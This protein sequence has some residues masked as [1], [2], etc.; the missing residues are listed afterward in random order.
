MNER[1]RTQWKTHVPRRIGEIWALHSHL[2]WSY[3]S[4]VDRHSLPPTNNGCS[5]C[6][7]QPAVSSTAFKS[8]SQESW[9]ATLIR[10]SRRSKCFSQ[11]FLS[12]SFFSIMLNTQRKLI[13]VCVHVKW[14][15]TRRFFS[16]TDATESGHSKVES[17][18]ET[19]C[20][21]S[22]SEISSG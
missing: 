7:A 20:C 12:V 16:L 3:W 10:S 14:C 1:C 8:C 21:V 2:G 22:S 11:I 4:S 17:S 19:Q 6:Q 13:A 18:A 5:N 15:G 9:T